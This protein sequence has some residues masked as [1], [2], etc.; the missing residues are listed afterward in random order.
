M[1][2]ESYGACNKDKESN[3]GHLVNVDMF[4]EHIGEFGKMQIIL[5]IMFCIMML[6]ATYQTLLLTFAANNPDWKCTGLSAECNN[7]NTIFHSSHDFYEQRCKFKNRSSWEF[8]QPKKFSIVTEWDLICEKN[9]L[10]Y[11]ANSALFLGWAVGALVLSAIADRFGRKSVLFPSLGTVILCGFI[12]AFVHNFWLFFVLRLITGFAQGGVGLSIYVLATE[13]VGPNFR[14]LSG[15]IVWFAFTAA[16]CLIG[17]KAYLVPDWRMLEIIVSAP[18]A[19]VIVF[20]KCVP[21][22]VRWLRVN[23]KVDEAEVILRKVAK[24]N[25]KIQPTVK[26]STAEKD[27]AHGTY[28]DLFRPASTCRDTLVQIGRKPTTIWSMFI[29]ALSCGAVA[30]IPNIASN[31]AYMGLRITLGMLGKLCIT[32]SFNELYVWSVELNP[33]IVRSQGMGLLQVISRIGAATAPWVAQWL[34]L[35]GD[36]LPFLLMGGLTMVAT[37]LCFTLK[38][39][40]GKETAEVFTRKS[41]P[42]IE[43]VTMVKMDHSRVEPNVEVMAIRRE[44]EIV[45]SNKD[46]TEPIMG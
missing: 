32:V 17:L 22:S 34:R 31:S 38:E 30:F 4:L 15:T 28:A 3:Q 41:K 44:D 35:Y 43:E 20:W 37:F 42:A 14:A 11:L 1:E 25:G 2:E 6:P 12:S 18:Y 10:S 21:E 23:D 7:T 8:V 39:T 45:L 27:T 26:L 33:T 5:Q 36:Y 24:T 46:V 9:S 16:L 29:G 19:F 13:L 40:K